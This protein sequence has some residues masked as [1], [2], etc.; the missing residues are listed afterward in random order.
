MVLVALLGGCETT[1]VGYD[2]IYEQG[3]SQFVECSMNVDDKN[4]VS[5][6]E[7]GA[8][9]DRA[10]LDETTLQLYA[11]KDPGTVEPALIETVLAA[12]A[13]RR[14]K[15]VTYAELAE[16]PVPASLAL[17]FDDHDLAG[18]SALRPTFDRYGAK[19]TFFVSSYPTFTDEMKAELRALAADGHDIEYHSTTHQNAEEYSKEHGVDAY[20]ADD[21]VPGLEA[22]R[23]DGWAPTMFAYPFGARTDATDEALRPLFQHVRAIHST[24]PY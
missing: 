16:H 14:I 5:L 11:H 22:M 7:I 4:A 3:A 19:V 8:S 17:S 10:Q 23:A 12:A 9:L 1:I 21:I 24:C 18:W 15:F 6:D 13:D 20:V 2:D